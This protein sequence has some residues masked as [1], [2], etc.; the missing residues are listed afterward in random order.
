MIKISSAEHLSV[1]IRRA[2]PGMPLERTTILPPGLPRRSDSLYFKLDR[3]GPEWAEI[4][5]QQNICLYWS[6]APEDTS[7]DIIVVRK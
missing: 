4:Q 6:H 7:A 3:G 5:K 2:L 1:L